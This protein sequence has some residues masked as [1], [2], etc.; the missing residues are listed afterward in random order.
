MKMSD[1]VDERLSIYLDREAS[2]EECQ[3]IESH[4]KLCRECQEK[5]QQLS[6]LK[7]E[8]TLFY[9][10]IEEPLLQFD[11][12]VMKNI[13]SLTLRS[14]EK[15]SRIRWF[16]AFGTLLLFMIILLKLSPFLF[17]GVKITEVLLKVS[18][19]L[20]HVL[21][22]VATSIPYFVTVTVLVTVVII[23]ITS[24]SLRHLLESKTIG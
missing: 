21:A 14:S 1:H 4:L 10:S 2:V 6:Q 9:C 8:L 11:Q 3:V 22:A 16:A 5:Y 7:E 17:V 12:S 15:I 18:Y 20:I 23:L 13:K 19:T 24:L